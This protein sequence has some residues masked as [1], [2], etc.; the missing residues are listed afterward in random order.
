VIRGIY[1]AG[2]GK[3]AGKTTLCLGLAGILG[4]MVPGGIS[5]Y[6]PLGQ[7]IT[8]VDGE[9]VGQ[10]SWFL[11]SA[12]G[13]PAFPED[14]TPVLAARGAAERF[15]RTGEPRGLEDSVKRCF[16][17]FSRESGLV[18]VEG[19]GHPGVGS[20]FRLGNADVASMLGIP[21][22]IVL[23]GGVGSTIDS[24]CL[25]RSMFESRRVPVLG[26]VVN[27]VLPSKMDTVEPVLRMWFQENGVPLFGVLPFDDRIAQPSISTIIREIGAFPMF[28]APV[29]P[30]AAGIG[31]ITAF[32]SA[33]QVLSRVDRDPGRALLV[34]S[35]RP[36]VL[37]SVIVS[38]LAGGNRPSA[39]VVCGGEPDRR[40]RDAC[41]AASIPLFHT[42]GSLEGS[43]LKLSRSLFK[44]EP[45]EREKIGHIKGMVAASVD[46]SA[47]LQALERLEGGDH[48]GP[49]RGIVG[50]LRKLFRRG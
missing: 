19:T 27:R 39:V 44:T 2:S 29:S 21:A 40:R 5:F 47:I 24:F 6:K 36:E 14:S 38:A 41:A 50:F 18:L 4:S 9:S 43:A 37:D 35:S 45:D 48:G 32:D 12:L 16:R 13:L 26:V 8:V 25:C 46:A 30:G 10:D 20:V 11:S 33:D 15:V 1:I 49:G 34:S 22:I 23:D 42:G 3:D 7:K 28:D 31:F 17:R